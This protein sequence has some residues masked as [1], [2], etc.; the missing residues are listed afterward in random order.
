MR[1]CWYERIVVP[2]V[3]ASFNYM[4]VSKSPNSLLA[5]RVGV[6]KK[7]SFCNQ[8]GVE[9]E[10]KMFVE[11][12][13][14]VSMFSISPGAKPSSPTVFLYPVAIRLVSRH[15]ALR[16]FLFPGSL[17]QSFC[18]FAWELPA[19]ELVS[20]NRNLVPLQATKPFFIFF[21][22]LSTHCLSNKEPQI[23]G[24]ISAT[25]VLFSSNLA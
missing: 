5:Q 16:C 4:F 1:R 14:K 25:W 2:V 20:L 21:S 19:N 13:W 10:A 24:F 15:R 17:C 18:C 8:M 9:A 23:I 3:P 22:S 7:R 6:K 12:L 11:C